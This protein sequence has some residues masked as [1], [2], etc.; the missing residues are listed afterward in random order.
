MGSF[1]RGMQLIEPSTLHR[2]PSLICRIT[3]VSYVIRP[4]RF[5]RLEGG[6]PDLGP[7]RPVGGRIADR[8]ANHDRRIT[9]ED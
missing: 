9:A 2:E 4:L 6:G 8:E 3:H 1:L 5:C 7:A